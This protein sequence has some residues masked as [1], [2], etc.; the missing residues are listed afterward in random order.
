MVHVYS[1]SCLSRA[2][3]VSVSNV[4]VF[5]EVGYFVS[6]FCRKSVGVRSV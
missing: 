6:V 4:E 3:D 2:L 1:G 5:E